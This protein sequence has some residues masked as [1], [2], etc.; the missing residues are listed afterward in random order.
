MG[1][2]KD[3]TLNVHFKHMYSLGLKKVISSK[4]NKKTLVIENT[5]LYIFMTKDGNVT[6]FH[7]KQLSEMKKVDFT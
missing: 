7:Y 1:L 3:T 4:I 2:Q 6:C 5:K